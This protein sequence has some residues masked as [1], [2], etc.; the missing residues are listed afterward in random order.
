MTDRHSSL[1]FEEA[2]ELAMRS[3]AAEGLR[4]FDPEAIGAQAVAHGA[5]SW[6]T[7]Q[8]P[9]PSRCPSS[10]SRCSSSCSRRLS[11]RSRLA[12][13]Q[14]VT[15]APP[16]PERPRCRR[17]APDRPARHGIEDHPRTD[18]AGRERQLPRLVAGRNPYRILT[19]RWSRGA[20]AH[21]RR[22]QQPPR[23]R[24]WNDLGGAGR[25][26]ARRQT[27]RVRRLPIPGRSR[28]WTLCRPSGRDG[29]RR[30]SCR[31]TRPLGSRSRGR[32][33]GRSS[34]S[35]RLMKVGLS[36]ALVGTSTSSTS[37]PAS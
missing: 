26:V 10:G 15:P 29:P 31:T 25:V 2:L 18:T 33:T 34:R 6:W 28:A 11:V 9:A 36:T 22:R 23:D 13:A 1:E 24:V 19:D 21:G 12:G 30:C 20:A 7:G 3:Y 5:R 35:P 16:I 27:D 32:P 4:S 37:P 8:S 17:H 14:L